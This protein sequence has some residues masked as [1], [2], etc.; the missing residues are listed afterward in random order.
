MLQ[1]KSAGSFVGPMQSGDK[2]MLLYL[3]D[4]RPGSEK[5]FAHKKKAIHNDIFSKRQ[6][7]LTNKL[8]ERLKK[9]YNVKINKDLLAEIDLITP[10]KENW[11][12]VL[13]TSDLSSV[14]VGYFIEQC[15]REQK[16]LAKQSERGKQMQASLKRRA[17]S[18]MISNSLVDWAVADRHYEE[19]AP[20]KWEYQFYRQGS[21]IK[22]LQKRMNDSSA[23]TGEVAQTYYN[24]H[25]SEF[26]SADMAKISL[27]HG[28]EDEINRLWG[29]GMASGELSKTEMPHTLV[30]LQHLSEAVRDTISQLT[31][32][33]ISSP[34]KDGGKF[35]L[36]QLY[37]RQPGRLAPFPQ[38][39]NGILAKL[40]KENNKRLRD[41]FIMKLRQRSSIKINDDVWQK[42]RTE[43]SK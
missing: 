14:N 1:D 43:F 3:V 5:D 27:V 31:L 21:L 23:V 22:L 36:V 15:R 4:L 2:F 32:N 34:F 13:V 39:R 12:K 6:R 10:K 41:E 28:N 16:V 9:I 17:M 40:K 20:F 8:L 24:D 37:E 18:A 25:Q 26:R 11:D 19:Q 38:V 7:E 42:I 30:P 29:A 35:A 33:D